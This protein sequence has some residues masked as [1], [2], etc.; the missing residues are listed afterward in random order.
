LKFEYPIV[1]T[2]II[3]YVLDNNVDIIICIYYV[4]DYDQNKEKMIESAKLYYQNNKEKTK[5]YYRNNE[6]IKETAKLYYQNNK[7]KILDRS[8]LYYQENKDKKQKYNQ[9][10]LGR[11]RS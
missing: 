3:Y 9:K 6:K 8:K 5:L 10:I 2:S 1:L 11:T 4:L 7:E